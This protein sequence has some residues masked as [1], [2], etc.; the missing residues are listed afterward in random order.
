MLSVLRGYCLLSIFFS[1]YA[2]S[3]EQDNSKC[4]SPELMKYALEHYSI[5][6]EDYSGEV[7]KTYTEKD[8]C[9]QDTL[10]AL[11][12]GID[13]L[14]KTKNTKI[15]KKYETIAKKEGVI[16]FF[17]KRVKTIII[18]Q[19]DSGLC[20][21]HSAAFVV[22]Y[23]AKDGKIYI[24]DTIKSRST[25]SVASIILHE[26][27][28]I[29]GFPHMK[30]T[31]GYFANSSLDACDIN[32]KQQGAY[33]IQLGYLYQVYYG[34]YNNKIKDEARQSIIQLTVDQFNT[35]LPGVRKGGLL[36]DDDDTLSFYDGIKETQFGSFNDKV[37]T[38]ILD[39]TY[40]VIFFKNGNITKYDFTR[41]WELI[42]GYTT[43][44]YKKLTQSERDS[45]L[46]VFFSSKD[47]C[48]LFKSLIKCKSKSQDEEFVSLNMNK[49]KPV[50]FWFNRNVD[51]HDMYVVGESMLIYK[52]PKPNEF[53]QTVDDKILNEGKKVYPQVTSYAEMDDGSLLGISPL[54]NVMR[55]QS[56]SSLWIPAKEFGDYKF[57]KI[58][59]F[60]WTKEFEDL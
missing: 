33:A 12:K 39:S 30:C 29:D 41:K 7:K 14:R 36:L 47:V 1:I 11:L 35:A 60:Y 10:G 54:G 19:P 31:H 32:F 18:L 45:L 56:K 3:A 51:D 58:L 46:D 8:N 17:N 52:L 49:I 43:E 55:K 16:Q 50:T 25:L 24:C 2:F 26:A 42:N 5:Y 13:F 44:T 37:A 23:E 59:P 9:N 6:S 57:K 22:D 27:R 40:P 38:V 15:P 4:I 20:D 48:F 34:K 21:E 28:H 53:V